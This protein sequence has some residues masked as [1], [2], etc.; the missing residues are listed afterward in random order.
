MQNAEG[1]ILLEIEGKNAIWENCRCG[2]INR[3]ILG[4]SKLGIY[5]LLSEPN[6]KSRILNTD[7]VAT[8]V[9]ARAGKFCQRT[10]PVMVYRCPSFALRATEDRKGVEVL[11]GE[12]SSFLHHIVRKTAPSAYDRMSTRLPGNSFLT[13]LA[14]YSLSQAPYC[15]LVP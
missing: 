15:S 8:E 14:A 12:T 9:R 13:S 1:L 11:F 10:N 7:P 5:V 4:L 2:L 6:V 3:E